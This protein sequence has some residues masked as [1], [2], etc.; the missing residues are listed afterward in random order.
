MQKYNNYF[1]KSSGY[2]GNSGVRQIAIY[3]FKQLQKKSRRDVI[4]QTGT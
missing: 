1:Q 3:D 4:L 2:N